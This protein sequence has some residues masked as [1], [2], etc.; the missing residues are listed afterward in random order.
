MKKAVIL[1][2]RGRQSYAEQEPEEIELV[3]EGTL[4]SSENGYVLCYEES[5]L[6]GLDGV[7]TTFLIQDDGVTLIRDGKLKSY[8]KFHK[9]V[10]HDSLYQT[11][12]GALMLSVCASKISTRLSADGGVVD[13][14]YS[15]EIEQTA[16]GTIDYHLEI[17][18][19]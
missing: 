1:S 16:A 17:R 3:T 6:T 7:K 19:K 12:F 14:V 11:E 15:I 10:T 8:M 13:L 4:E 18:P 9:G 5:D 2:I